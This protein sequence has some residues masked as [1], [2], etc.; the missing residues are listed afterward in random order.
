MLPVCKN[1][2]QPFPPHTFSFPL[3]GL[4]FPFSPL[5]T[6][7]VTQTI[8]KGW[9]RVCS[10]EESIIAAAA[11]CKERFGSGNNNSSNNESSSPSLL[12]LAF[13]IPGI[14]LH[15]EKSPLAINYED[16]LETFKINTLGPALLFKHFSQFLPTKRS[17]PFPTKTNPSFSSSAAS[18]EKEEETNGENETRLARMAV[19][20]IMSAR[21][22]SISDNKSGGWY[23]YRAS[24]AGVNQLVKGFDIFLKQKSGDKAVVVGLHPGTVKTGLSE[25]FWASTAKEKLFS[26]EYSAER[27]AG[28]VGGLNVEG[29]GKCW[30]SKGVEIPP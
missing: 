11:Q 25:Q 27:L 10:E 12:R 17:P 5:S 22:G 18:S 16:G 3:G 15:P 23:T 30:D 28:V 4:I 9:K 24:K 1:L 20:A 29:R 26:P 6:R 7:L 2:F 21:V 19:F 14:L 8:T 13:A